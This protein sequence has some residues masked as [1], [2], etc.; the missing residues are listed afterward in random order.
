MNIL[1]SRRVPQLSSTYQRRLPLKFH[2]FRS[3]L[4]VNMSPTISTSTA[5]NTEL[6]NTRTRCHDA[7]IESK[8]S[9]AHS[10]AIEERNDDPAIRQKYRP[11]LLGTT[12]TAVDWINGLELDGVMEMA[13][14]DLSNTGERLKVLVLYGSLRLRSVL[15]KRKL[16]AYVEGTY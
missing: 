6:E 3:S 5:S 11:F 9:L 7:G 13:A 4:A 15:R 10:L 16:Y 2:L 14:R 12:A 1:L 8:P